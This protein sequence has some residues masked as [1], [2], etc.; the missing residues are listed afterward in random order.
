MAAGLPAETPVALV[1]NASLPDER[2]IGTRLDLLPLAAKA[3]L[4]SGPALLL[5]GAALGGGST[6]DCRS[7]A[8]A[9]TASK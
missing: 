6:S 7:I 3:G 9:E 2:R 8:T 5:I 4:G 1:E